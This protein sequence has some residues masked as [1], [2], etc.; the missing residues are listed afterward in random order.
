M[1]PIIVNDEVR[2][3]IFRVVSHAWKNIIPIAELAKSGQLQ[4][5]MPNPIGDSMDHVVLIPQAFKVV[6]S[7]EDQGSEKING[8]GGLGRC[9]HLSMSIN[10]PG[11]VPNPIA[12]D[13]IVEEFGFDNPLYHCAVWAENFGDNTLLAIN[14]LEPVDGWPDKDSLHIIEEN[15][16]KLFKP[17]FGDGL[18]KAIDTRRD[19]VTT[20]DELGT[21]KTE[22]GRVN[23]NLGS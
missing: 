19:L 15:N 5:G 17:L 2:A 13:M 16:M 10:K 8:R 20:T 22:G 4:Q 18:K 7:I 3:E 9:R 23:E 11:R 1:T 12:V 6:F 21:S 14:V